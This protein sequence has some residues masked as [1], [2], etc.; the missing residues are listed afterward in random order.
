MARPAISILQLD[1]S[2]PR[3]P[4]DVAAAA[5]YLTE[6][7]ILRVPRATVGN[8]VTGDPV[9]VDIRGFCTAIEM[10]RGDMI[11][12][13][14]GF[15]APFKTRLQAAS[16]VPVV[17]SALDLLPWLSERYPPAELAIVTFDAT[18][19]GPKHV[20]GFE[21]YAA[22]LIGLD[23][24]HHLRTVI[25]TDAAELD[26]RRAGSEI[27][28]QVKRH[29]PNSARAVLLECTNLPPYA[30]DLRR[31]LGVPVYDILTAIERVRP[32]TVRPEFLV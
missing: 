1:T 2:F 26:I 17:A 31:A 27:V 9:D 3:V 6:P 29:L 22:N 15:L 7:E 8:T 20:P 25:E 28:E 18:R 19:L 10:A 16:A 32:E 23:P 12:T 14:C 4:G 24:A 13:S 11:A 5:T 30:K 21:A